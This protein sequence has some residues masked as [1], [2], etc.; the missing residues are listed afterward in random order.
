MDERQ[1]LGL[2]FNCNEKFR[3][4]HNYVC[5]HLFL[6]TFADEDDDTESPMEP[7]A[8]EPTISVLAISGVRTRETM[9]MGISICGTSFRALLDSGS[10]HNFITEEAAA[11]TDLVLRPQ[12]VIRVTVANGDR[13]QS[14]SVFRDTSFIIESERF[15]ADLHTLPL[16]SCNVVLGMHWLAT[17]RPILWDFG[18]PHGILAWR[19]S[20][21][22]AG[23]GRT[24]EP[25]C[26]GK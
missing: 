19:P 26:G 17:L 4:D 20:H 21:Q 10:T 2:C 7:P 8:D 9:Q 15:V 24:A 16:A 6:I 12:G 11:C 18:S 22:L 5:Q 14:P 1:R 13:V 23:L 25:L 3:R